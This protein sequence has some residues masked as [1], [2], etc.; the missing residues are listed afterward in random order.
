MFVRQQ[1][2]RNDKINDKVN[3]SLDVYCPNGRKTILKAKPKYVCR[4][5][6]PSETIGIAKII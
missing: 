5:T 1:Q 3:R 6:F 2:N 4:E